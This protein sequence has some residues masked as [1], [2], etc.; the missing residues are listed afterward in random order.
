MTTQHENPRPLQ[1]VDLAVTPNGRDS[2]E[3]RGTT[4]AAG[5]RGTPRGAL[6]VTGTLYHGETIAPRNRAAALRWLE[7]IGEWLEDNPDGLPV[8][9][10][11]AWREDENETGGEG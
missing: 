8:L 3:T 4:V 5:G 2:S 11:G 9:S 10:V 1:W 6:R 7:V